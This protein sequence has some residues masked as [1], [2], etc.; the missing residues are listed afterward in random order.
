MRNVW[1]KAKIR[2]SSKNRKDKRREKR[3]GREAERV[4]NTKRKVRIL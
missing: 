4:R 1:E 2:N 3:I